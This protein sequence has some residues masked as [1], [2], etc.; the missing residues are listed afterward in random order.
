MLV[1]GILFYNDED[2]LAHFTMSYSFII[3]IN[4]NSNFWCLTYYYYI[5][6]ISSTIQ[7]YAYL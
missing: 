4:P 6:I 1:L 3:A 5:I 7:Y 2:Y